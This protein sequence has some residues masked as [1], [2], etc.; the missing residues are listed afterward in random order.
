MPKVNKMYIDKTIYNSSPEKCE[1]KKE[2]D[3]YI[4][5]ENCQTDYVRASH[6]AAATI[7]LCEEVEKIIGAKICKNLLLCNRQCTEFYMLLLPGSLNF[8]TKYL[9]S[10]IGS[11]R[12]SFA[13]GE[14]MEALLNVSPGSLTVLSLMYDKEKKVKLLIEKSLFSEEY[15]ACHPCVN[16]A[17]VRFKT[18][19]LL[20]KVLPALGR[21]YKTVDLVNVPTE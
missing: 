21:E 11:S 18:E 10:Q 2:Q 6:D 16:T 19:D 5:L 7:E 1:T 15:F 4:L 3:S 12:L 17:T 14:Q 9:S 13:S 20:K 8:K